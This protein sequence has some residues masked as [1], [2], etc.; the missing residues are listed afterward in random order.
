[1]YE[2]QYM[3]L[4]LTVIFFAMVHRGSAWQAVQIVMLDQQDTT[5]GK[6]G[7]T[8]HRQFG[9]ILFMRPSPSY[10]LTFPR[11]LGLQ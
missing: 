3:A 1:M 7:S 10:S 11:P 2:S 6:L 9:G 4:L 5:H 8:Y